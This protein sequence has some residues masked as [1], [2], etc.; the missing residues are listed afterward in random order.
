[1][2]VFDNED[3]VKRSIVFFNKLP[4]MDKVTIVSDLRPVTFKPS[5]YYNHLVPLL[6]EVQLAISKFDDIVI[7]NRLVDLGLEDTYARLFVL[8][9]KKHAP[10]EEYQLRQISKISDDVFSKSI[11]G[12]IKSIWAHDASEDELAEKFSVSKEQLRCVVDVARTALNA[13]ARGD[14]TKESM[15]ERYSDKLSPDKFESLSNTL[16]VSQKY[17]Y[18]SLLFSNAQDSYHSINYIMKQNDVLIKLLHEM[19]DA[20]QLDA[21]RGRSQ[22]G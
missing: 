6:S 14:M 16:L 15:R 8:N 5:R 10:T 22:T 3:G 19:L 7:G 2:R 20:L 13:L 11:A 12:I 1:M 4:D 9:I 21:P 17:W 18:D